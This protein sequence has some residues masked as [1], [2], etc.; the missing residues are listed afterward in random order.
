MAV[1]MK[2]VVFWDLTL[3]SSVTHSDIFLEPGAH[4]FSV[5]E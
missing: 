1:N 3:C 4:M 5:E 2:T